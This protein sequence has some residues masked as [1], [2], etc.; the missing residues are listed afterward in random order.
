MGRKEKECW[1]KNISWW[2]NT[3]CATYWCSVLFLNSLYWASL[4]CVHTGVQYLLLANL[5]EKKNPPKKP[6]KVFVGGELWGKQKLSYHENN[7]FYIFG[8]LCQC[9]LPK[10]RWWCGSDRCYEK[11]KKIKSFFQNQRLVPSTMQLYW[12][13]WVQKS[14]ILENYLKNPYCFLLLDGTLLGESS[15]S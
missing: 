2:I 11:S 12:H 1:R 10:R 5:W 4:A 15:L 6:N 3:M 14:I 13:V 7:M 9:V 8:V